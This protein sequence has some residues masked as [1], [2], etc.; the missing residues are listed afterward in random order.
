MICMIYSGLL[1]G[2][3]GDVGRKISKYTKIIFKRKKKKRIL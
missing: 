1:G 3:G 2:R